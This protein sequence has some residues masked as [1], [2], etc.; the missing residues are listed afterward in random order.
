MGSIAGDEDNSEERKNSEIDGKNSNGAKAK[1]LKCSRG[2]VE[3][4][5][6][7]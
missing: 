7:R 6:Q 2:G 1:K 3:A 5:E 4:S